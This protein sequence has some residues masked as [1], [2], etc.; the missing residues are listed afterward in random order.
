MSGPWS[1]FG[2]GLVGRC[3]RTISSAFRKGPFV[4]PASSHVSPFRRVAVGAVGV[5]TVAAVTLAL[6]PSTQAAPAVTVGAT[7]QSAVVARV[8]DGDTFTTTA[9][10]TVRVLGLDSPEKTECYGSQAT[11][12]AKKVLRPGTRVTLTRDTIQPA[13]DRY[14]RDLRH[15]LIKSGPGAGANYGVLA[16]RKGYGESYADT[17]RNMLTAKYQSAERTAKKAGRG[18]WSACHSS[19]GSSSSGSGSSVSG[20]RCDPNYSGF[21]V[22]VVSY[23]LDCGDIRHPVRVIGRD[24]H[25]FDGDGDGYGCESY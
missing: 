21:C 19:S 24:I 6:A 8:I 4:V 1:R 14:G 20:N 5:S 22:P 17:Y 9:G 3:A 10:R 16:I 18:L 7:T 11:G 25:N 2:S 12:Y 13:K 15:V 23:D